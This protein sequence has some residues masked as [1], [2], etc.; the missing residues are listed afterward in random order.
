MAEETEE[1]ML[2]ADVLQALELLVTYGYYDGTDD[3]EAIL[4]PLSG[5][6]NGFSDVPFFMDKHRDRMLISFC[7][8]T[9][10]TLVCV[11]VCCSSSHTRVCLCV[12]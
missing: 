12:L 2:L 6:L 9:A 3:V 8:V 11:C 1:N 7:V 4:K 5:V 10:P